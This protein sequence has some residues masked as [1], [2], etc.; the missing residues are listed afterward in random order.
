MRRLDRTDRR[1]LAILQEDAS[2]SVADVASRVGLSQTPRL[3]GIQRLRSEGVIRVK[4]TTADLV[5]AAA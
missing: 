2:L 4:S 3:P 5:E 1:I